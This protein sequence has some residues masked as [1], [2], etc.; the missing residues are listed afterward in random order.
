MCI[1]NLLYCLILHDD[2]TVT[3]QKYTVTLLHFISLLPTLS[4]YHEK[5]IKTALIVITYNNV[6]FFVKFS[7]ADHGTY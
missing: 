5:Y 1:V 7:R 3:S 6:P 4:F 2:S